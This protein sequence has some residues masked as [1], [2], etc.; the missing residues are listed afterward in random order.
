MSTKRIWELMG[1]KLAGEAS[2]EEL[3][4]LDGLLRAHPE[5]HL[6][7][8]TISDLWKQPLTD[9]D[10][11]AAEKAHDRHI[12][13]MQQLGIP[14]GLRSED[15]DEPTLLLEGTRKSKNYIRY[16]VAAVAVGLIAGA[17]WWL[18]PS[19]RQAVNTAPVSEVLTR[20]GSRTT[21]VLPDGTKVWLNA[22]SRITYDKDFGNESR[23]IT[24]TGEAFF[25]VTKNAR[26][27]FIIH[28]AEMDIRVL[29]TRFNVRSYPEDKI[30]E[31]ALIQGSIEAS[32]K[33]RPAEK[34]I[35]KP[36]EKIIVRSEETLKKIHT[37]GTVQEEPVITVQ[38]LTYYEGKDNAVVE[39][40]WMENKLV[41]RDE[42]FVSLA[43]QME[44]WYGV[45]VTFKDKQKEDLRFTGIFEQE[46]VQQALEALKMIAAFNYTIH[47][48]EII[49]NQ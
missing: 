4:E 9:S 34:I 5:L 33:D 44:R 8:E 39:T 1:R 48:K 40:L 42:S 15:A 47:G 35:L 49:I 26:R 22:G 19:G 31:A 30:T 7:I 27:P 36:S 28:T 14:V 12:A 25:D 3:Q 16:L 21:L 18:V 11:S 23:E 29:G 10:R 17:T 45:T 46:N 37:S 32:P 6:P 41:F 43:K 38:H 2:A 20:N 13:R 24:L